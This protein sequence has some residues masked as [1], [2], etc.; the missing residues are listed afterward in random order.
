MRIL[1]A[2]I[3]DPTQRGEKMPPMLCVSV[4]EQ[5]SSTGIDLVGGVTVQNYGPFAQH[6]Q[7]LGDGNRPLITASRWNVLQGKHGRPTVDVVVFVGDSEE[8]WG[9]YTMT[10]ARAKQLIKKHCKEWRLYVNE[11]IAETGEIAWTP[12]QQNPTCREW[13]GGKCCGERPARSVRVGAFE[14]PLCSRH[15][16]AH[17]DRRAEARRSSKSS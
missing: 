11:R 9:E 8:P 5:P 13:V 16:T 3:D 15:L 10:L 4:D 7:L 14:M 2:W 1:D 6:Y 12:V 17:N